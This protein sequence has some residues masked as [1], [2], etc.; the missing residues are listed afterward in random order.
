[1]AEHDGEI[2]KIQFDNNKICIFLIIPSILDRLYKWLDSLSKGWKDC[3]ISIL[4]MP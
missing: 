3:N 2:Q 4:A 1:M